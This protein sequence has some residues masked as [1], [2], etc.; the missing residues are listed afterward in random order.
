MW[1]HISR[2]QGTSEPHPPR[3]DIAPPPPWKIYAPP[4]QRQGGVLALSW[5]RNPWKTRKVFGVPVAFYAIQKRL[6]LTLTSKTRIFREVCIQT[7]F[8][9]IHWSSLVVPRRKAQC[10]HERQIISSL[11][12]KMYKE[13][14]ACTLLSTTATA[15]SN[16]LMDKFKND[17]DKILQL[18]GNISLNPN[19]AQVALVTQHQLYIIYFP[20]QNEFV[21]IVGAWKWVLCRILKW[22]DI[23]KKTMQQ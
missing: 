18:L 3:G 8:I 12:S 17:N 2:K 20:K 23:T 21:C 9:I 1:L 14:L 13:A 7:I 5:G 16:V 4:W 22:S 19:E 10:L 11:F 6:N 15:T